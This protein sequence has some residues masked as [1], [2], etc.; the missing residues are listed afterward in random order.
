MGIGLVSAEQ[1]TDAAR[2]LRVW[3]DEASRAYARA[4]R[5]DHG[6]TPS[7][8]PLGVTG[9]LLHPTDEGSFRSTGW[10]MRDILL[11]TN[12]GLC[13]ERGVYGALSHAQRVAPAQTVDAAIQSLVGGGSAPVGLVAA[14]GP[15]LDGLRNNFHVGALAQTR[16]GQLL[17]LD[18]LATSA[19]DGVLALDEWMRRIHVAPDAVRAL[20]SLRL[21][22]NNLHPRAG[23]PILDRQLPRDF[24]DMAGTN[25][26]SR[27]HHAAKTGHGHRD[28]R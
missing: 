22:P 21:P 5:G 15:L 8:A 11:H 27:W 10:E 4:L 19:D 24:F 28:L 16:E 25:L 17:V 26:A 14:W 1:A 12:D 2:R 9:R 20:S 7:M 18:H 6:G 23:L 13:V 3:S